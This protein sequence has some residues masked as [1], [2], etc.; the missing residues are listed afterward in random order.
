MK[1]AETSSNQSSVKQQQHTHARTHLVETRK[2]L[3]SEGKLVWPLVPFQQ[4]LHVN[5]RCG[6]R[7]ASLPSECW[8]ERTHKQAHA[9]VRSSSI[10][11]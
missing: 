11:L 5:F 3:R 2:V 8:Y 4:L 9:D 10:D 7:D 6:G 1:G